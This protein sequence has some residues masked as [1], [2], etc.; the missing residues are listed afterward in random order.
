M[1]LIAFNRM[2][3]RSRRAMKR[4]YKFVPGGY[5][6]VYRYTPRGNLVRRLMKELNMNYESVR[7]QIDKERRKLLSQQG[8]TINAGEIV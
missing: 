5:R 8:Y 2:S 7:A 4:R 1:Q 6:Q 3:T